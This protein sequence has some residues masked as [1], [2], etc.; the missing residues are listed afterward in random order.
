[1]KLKNL[2]VSL[3]PSKILTIIIAQ[4]KVKDLQ[5][6]Q[7]NSQF[8]NFKNLSTGSVLHQKFIEVSEK[9]TRID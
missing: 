3:L 5:L 2:K 1:M 6:T 4:V 8:E 9:V 7:I